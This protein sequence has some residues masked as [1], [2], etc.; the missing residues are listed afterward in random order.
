MEWTVKDFGHLENGEL[1]KEFTITNKNGVSLR[2]ISYGATWTGYFVTP[3]KNIILNFDNVHEYETNPFHLGN[4]IGRV[5][6]RLSGH[7]FN[8]AGFRVNLKPNE[9]KNVLHSGN[10]GV[11]RLNWHGEIILD[12]QFA[13]IRYTMQQKA[14][15]PGTLEM[16]VT[17]SLDED[18]HVS[19]QYEGRSNVETLFNPM[20]HVY[21]NLDG[22]D[23]SIKDEFLKI[24]ADRHIVVNEEK[25]P[26]GEI[27]VVE[28]TPFDFTNL[29]KLGDQCEKLGGNEQFDDA[30][31]KPNTSLGVTPSLLLVDSAKQHQLEMGSDR[32]GVIIFNVNPDCI[33]KDA[34]WLA[35]HPDNGLAV[36]LQTVPDAIHHDGF[37]DIVL[38]ANQT[39]TYTSTY[40]YSEG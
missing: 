31:K 8:V 12:D 10:T 40:Y 34:D 26:T 3:E 7:T 39:K 22:P 15:F 23:A 25:I 14:I 5:A 28:N 1:V 6:G 2:T 21:F 20:T 35:A 36:E 32:N 9:N 27:Q 30:F 17:Y 24:V 33:G 19:V 37:G 13:K 18:N 4:T 11:D 38:P 16:A 29:V